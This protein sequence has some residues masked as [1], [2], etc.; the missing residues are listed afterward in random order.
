MHAVVHAADIQ[1]RD[2][3]VLVLATLFGMFPFLRKIFADS[4]YQGPHFRVVNAPA[5]PG[6][7]CWYKRATYCHR[8]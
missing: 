7:G 5:E 8:R 2:G 6:A 3:G 4:G 1:D